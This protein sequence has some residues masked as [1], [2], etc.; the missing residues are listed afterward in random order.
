MGR[1]AMGTATGSFTFHY[2]RDGKTLSVFTVNTD[3]RLILNYA[4]LTNRVDR[5]TMEQFHRKISRIPPFSDIAADFTKWPTVK[6]GD[7]ISD[8]AWRQQFKDAVAWL[9]DEVASRG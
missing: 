5:E 4:W 9:H 7:A 6:V 2:L 8:P 3:G 1:A